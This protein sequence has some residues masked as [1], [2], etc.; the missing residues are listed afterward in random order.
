MSNDSSPTDAIAYPGPESVRR[1]DRAIE[2]WFTILL[3]ALIPLIGALFAPAEWKT[4]LHVTGGAL[5]A[6]GLVLLVRHE[7]EIRRGGGLADRR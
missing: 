5:C 6:W 1:G 2:P 3:S 4:A 7:I